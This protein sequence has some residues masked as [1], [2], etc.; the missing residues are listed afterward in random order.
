MILTANTAIQ[1]RGRDKNLLQA[2]NTKIIERFYYWFETQGKRIEI[3][4]T[5]VGK[6]YFLASRTIENI[7]QANSEL[8]DR[9]YKK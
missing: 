2:R 9:L 3:A 4:Y 6:E 8:L 7:I 5:N 1:S